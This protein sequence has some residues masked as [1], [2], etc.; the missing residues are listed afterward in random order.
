MK[1]ASVGKFGFRFL[2]TVATCGGVAVA[3]ATPPRLDPSNPPR[4]GTKYYPSESRR[5]HEEGVCKVKMT[6]ADGAIR[7]IKLT[8]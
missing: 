8:L 4:I 1:N 5:L 3:L 7:D 2:L 6:V